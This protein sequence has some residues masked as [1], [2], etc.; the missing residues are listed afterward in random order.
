MYLT[1]SLITY[2][3]GF[4]M[5]MFIYILA[6]GIFGGGVLASLLWG[7]NPLQDIII[8]TMVAGIAAGYNYYTSKKRKG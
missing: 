7:K 2:K 1:Q 4:N 6:T 3:G 5:E 8:V